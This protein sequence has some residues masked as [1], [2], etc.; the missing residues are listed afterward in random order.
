MDLDNTLWDWF[1]AWHL[2]FGPMLDE[3]VAQSG[4]DRH[5]LEQE[6]R[7]V[8][9]TVGTTEYSLLLSALPS[10][11]ARHGSDPRAVLAEYDHALHIQNKA[12][13]ART[14]LYPG[15][16]KTLEAVKA[17]G[18]GLVAYTESIDFWT[19][20]RIKH[21]DLDGLIDVLYSS[22]DHPWPE[23]TRPEDL[24]TLPLAAYGLERT[25][26]Q[27]VPR[28]LL[29]PQPE[30][31][32]TI[33]AQFDV[34]AHETAYIGDSLTK[35]IVMAQSVG[36]LDVHAKYGVSDHRDEYQLLRRVSH[37]T[38]GMIAAERAAAPGHVIEP[39]YVVE[40]F[41]E[42]VDLFSF[43]PSHEET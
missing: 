25:D 31:L 4:V 37:W 43:A 13:R 8:H 19:E 7:A 6:I 5:L 29:K 28:G 2:S 1:E 22:P 9:Q 21:T 18:V 30:V 15:V 26:H 36:V 34:P 20:W 35:D 38:D 11:V 10:L 32:R 40:D 3:V 42:I 23:G 14:V 16:H 39:T 12:R 24:R 33:L 17:T 27:H 41:S